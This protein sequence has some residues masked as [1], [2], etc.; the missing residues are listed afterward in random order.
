[1][2]V[3]RIFK[4]TSGILKKTYDFRLTLAKLKSKTFLCSRIV[5]LDDD[6]IKR[7]IKSKKFLIGDLVQGD[8]ALNLSFEFAKQNGFKMSGY[9]L[10]KNFDYCG[11]YAFKN[12]VNGKSVLEMCLIKTFKDVNSTSISLYYLPNGNIRDA[13]FVARVCK[14]NSE[15]K[16][17]DG[18]VVDKNAVHIHISTQKQFDEIYRKYKHRGEKV[19]LEKLQSPNAVTRKTICE[20]NMGD[21]AKEFFNISD[22]VL[23]GYSQVVQKRKYF[24]KDNKICRGE[25]SL[26]LIDEMSMGM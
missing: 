15:H 1:M 3:M 13:A 6:I 2:L 18:K 16:N 23:E 26:T 20:E 22:S 12:V 9:G 8:N 17:S 25:S 19:V 7:V 4:G 11:I 14:H 10:D 24:V 21:F 5:K